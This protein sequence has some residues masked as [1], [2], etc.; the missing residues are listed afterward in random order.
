MYARQTLLFLMCEVPKSM[1]L[2]LPLY[3][4][5]NIV[6]YSSESVTLMLNSNTVYEKLCAESINVI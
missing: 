6:M 2:S 3:V 1:N 5:N 4:N